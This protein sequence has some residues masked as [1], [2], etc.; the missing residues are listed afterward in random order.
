MNDEERDAD[1]SF[2]R[3]STS[4]I[5]LLLELICRAAQCSA[6]ALGGEVAASSRDHPLIYRA[7]Q[8]SAAALGGEVAA[9]SRDHPRRYSRF[10]R[11]TRFPKYGFRSSINLTTIGLRSSGG[12]L[13]A[14]S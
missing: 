2:I 6:A 1:F 11:R 12:I 13:S 7:A 8:C 4:F 10:L 14:A 5:L 3:Q 9:S